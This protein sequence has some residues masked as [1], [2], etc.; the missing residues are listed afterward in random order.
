VQQTAKSAAVVTT[1]S[2]CAA[3]M[4]RLKRPKVSSIGFLH[5]SPAPNTKGEHGKTHRQ[6]EF[7]YQPNPENRSAVLSAR[8]S[9]LLRDYTAREV[10]VTN[11]LKGP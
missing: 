8:V 6:Q 7:I 11:K 10:G 5:F 9:K 2:S 3:S 1:T 4:W